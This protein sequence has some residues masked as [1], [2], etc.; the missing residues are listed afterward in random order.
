MKPLDRSSVRAHYS[1]AMHNSEARA[2]SRERFLAVL[3]V[4]LFAAMLHAPIEAALA[5]TWGWI[6]A[7]IVGVL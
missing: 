1:P 7:R 6:V 5:R 4:L 3:V 2:L